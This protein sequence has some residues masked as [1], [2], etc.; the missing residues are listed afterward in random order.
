LNFG[1]AKILLLDYKEEHKYKGKEDYRA[2]NA[3]EARTIY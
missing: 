2:P 1:G 3:L